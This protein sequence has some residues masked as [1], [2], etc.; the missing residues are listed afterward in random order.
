MVKGTFPNADGRLWPGLFVNVVLTLKTE[1][2]A[3]VAP[4]RAVQDAPD[5]KYVYV[6]KADRTVES[7][8]ITVARAAGD[9]SVIASGLTTGETVVTDGQLRLVAGK[10]VTIDKPA[11]EKAAGQR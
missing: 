4:T 9:W 10:R 2:H 5:G 8:V 6:V 3:I 11:A 7:R 1:S